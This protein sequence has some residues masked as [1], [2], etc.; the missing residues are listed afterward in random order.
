MIL[1]MRGN[2]AE[3]FPSRLAVVAAVVLALLAF[4]CGPAATAFASE[5]GHGLVVQTPPQHAGHGEAECAHRATKHENSCCKD[6]SSWLTSRIDDGTPLILSH[7]SHRHLPA[8]TPTYIHLNFVGPNGE[9]RLT[10]PPSVRSIYG[11]SLY[12]RTQRYRI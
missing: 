3:T 11:T 9:P 12:S 2:R 4:P 5:A 6:C 10:G 8:V 7:T 1:K